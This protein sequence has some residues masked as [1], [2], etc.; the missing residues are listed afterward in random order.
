MARLMTG[1]I[2]QQDE[3]ARRLHRRPPGGE[4]VRHEFTIRASRQGFELRTDPSVRL[5][6]DESTTGTRQLD[7]RSPGA[8]V[9]SVLSIKATKNP[10]YWSTFVLLASPR[11]L[12]VPNLARVWRRFVGGLILAFRARPAN[13]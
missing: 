8:Y 3:P 10:L 4:E 6:M 9:R 1:T 5:V 2:H 11:L 12:I 13:S 7:T